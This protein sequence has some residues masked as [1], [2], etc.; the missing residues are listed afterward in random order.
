MVWQ[1]VSV[2][3]A[4]FNASSPGVMTRGFCLPFDSSLL[5]LNRKDSRFG[6]P[7]MF[8]DHRQCANA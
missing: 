3:P 4:G 7:I 1:T 5:E 2:I 8:M 6:T